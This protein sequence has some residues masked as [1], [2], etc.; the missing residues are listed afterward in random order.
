MIKAESIA[1]VE[2]ERERERAT[3]L[4]NNNQAKQLALLSIFKT[5]TKHKNV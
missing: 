5:G 1:G 3:T 4:I 2:R